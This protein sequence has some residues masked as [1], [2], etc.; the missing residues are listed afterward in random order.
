MILWPLLKLFFF[1]AVQ[2]VAQ[3]PAGASWLERAIWL[4]LTGLLL[5]NQFFG[6]VG[7]KKGEIHETDTAHISSLKGLNETLTSKCVEQEKEIK[8]LELSYGQAK[9]ELM[10]LALIE[11]GKLL[12]FAAQKRELDAALEENKELRRRLAEQAVEDAKNELARMSGEHR[13]EQR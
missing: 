8:G 9:K 12:N 5:A 13:R 10:A 11:V 1:L 4:V 3:P 2:E 7:K 6:I